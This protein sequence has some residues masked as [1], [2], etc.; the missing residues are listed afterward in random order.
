MSLQN[1]AATHF[2]KP[3]EYQNDIYICVCV[4]IYIY[5][6][7]SLSRIGVSVLN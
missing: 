1:V 4:N 3:L 7:L 2:K 6:S 5:I